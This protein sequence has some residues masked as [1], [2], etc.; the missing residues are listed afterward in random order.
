MSHIYTSLAY[1]LQSNKVFLEASSEEF[2][3][4]LSQ[5]RKKQFSGSQIDIAKQINFALKMVAKLVNNSKHMY[6]INSTM[7][8]E[9]KFICQ[10]LE[11]DSGINFET[12][13][14]FIIPR[15][16]TASLFGDSLL[17]SW[18]GYFLVLK[19]WWYV[20]FP[21]EIVMRMLNHLKNNKDSTLISI[22]C[23]EYITIIINYCAALTA[24]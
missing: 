22:N 6:V 2:K 7:Q 15:I 21:Q 8:E 23:L 16:P 4:I 10:A 3:L 19:I 14:A 17:Q 1:A 11:E 18:G 9:L 20:K 5:L 12:P 24:F 13:I